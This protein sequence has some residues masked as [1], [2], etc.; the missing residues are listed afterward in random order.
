MLF[1][2]PA[3]K[4]PRTTN[5]CHRILINFYKS[6]SY[7]KERAKTLKTIFPSS[8]VLHCKVSEPQLGQETKTK[9][10]IKVYILLLKTSKP[11]LI[12]LQYKLKV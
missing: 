1:N 8:M 5:K 4:D 9:G 10:P 11:S 2:D 7:K 3:C 12:L 6:N